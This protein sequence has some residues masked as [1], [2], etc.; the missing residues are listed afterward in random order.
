MIR[1]K[2]K[3][4]EK[5][6]IFFF[7]QSHKTNP[8]FRVVC[9]LKIGKVADYYVFVFYFKG[10]NKTYSQK[11]KREGLRKKNLPVLQA[12]PWP[13]FFQPLVKAIVKTIK[14]A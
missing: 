13:Q 5:Y 12:K 4:Q 7:I 6:L 1:G 3:D 8:N 2:N 9:K 11:Y 10:E 14:R